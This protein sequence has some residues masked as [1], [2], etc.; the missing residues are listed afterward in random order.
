MGLR[1]VASSS[2]VSYTSLYRMLR[3]VAKLST[4]VIDR[5]A[6]TLAVESADV[7]AAIERER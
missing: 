6:T 5:L 7:L 4:D 1:E 3:G 2:G